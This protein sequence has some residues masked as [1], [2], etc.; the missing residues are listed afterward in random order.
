[1]SRREKWEYLRNNNTDT[2]HLV[3]DAH[4]GKVVLMVPF[5]LVIADDSDASFDAAMS[6]AVLASAAPE[7]LAACEAVIDSGLGSHNH[8]DATQQSGA[9]CPLCIRQR[10]AATRVRAAIAKATGGPQ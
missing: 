3:T 8:W 5:D 7:L 9:G 2:A 10:E 1:M 4:S 6:R